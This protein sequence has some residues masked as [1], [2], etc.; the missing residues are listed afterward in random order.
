MSSAP[1]PTPH[2]TTLPLSP[3]NVITSG[4]QLPSIPVTLDESVMQ[5]CQQTNL[6]LLLQRV[7]LYAT[8]GFQLPFAQLP[9]TSLVSPLELNQMTIAGFSQLAT[10]PLSNASTLSTPS[11]AAS[12]P[13][14]TTAPI[15]A[16][17]M[18][19]P[20]FHLP[21]PQ[22][23]LTLASGFVAPIP[24]IITP[25]PSVSVSPPNASASTSS[26]PQTSSTKLRLLQRP[27]K[28][29]L[30]V[31]SCSFNRRQSAPE[32]S[33]QIISRASERRRYSDFSIDALLR[34][35]AQQRALRGDEKKNNRKQRTIYGLRQTEVLEEA[36][37]SQRYMVGTERET[38][39]SRLGL[40][41]AQVRVW[42][43]NRRS[44]QR[45]MNRQA[46]QSEQPGSRL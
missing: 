45:K 14:M 29:E 19:T 12:T 20:S 22:A 27:Y 18:P 10:S 3:L 34:A 23:N 24:Q 32:Q 11:L 38:L 26:M 8:T 6:E 25:M 39:A 36:F 4:L 35:P 44:K 1:S 40:S 21:L 42:F 5:T 30:A 15:N 46:G 2:T 9:Q 17:Q 16:S 31:P 7:G 33:I 43:Q 28:D 37:H 13:T 41:E